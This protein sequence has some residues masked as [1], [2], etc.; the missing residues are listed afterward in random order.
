MNKKQE[1]PWEW[2]FIIRSGENIIQHNIKQQPFDGS[3]VSIRLNME[4][5]LMDQSLQ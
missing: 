5:P 2:L 4:K 1:D 3:A